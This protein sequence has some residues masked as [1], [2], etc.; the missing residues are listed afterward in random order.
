M[1]CTVIRCKGRKIR[2]CLGASSFFLM[3][4]DD[5]CT[6]IRPK[7]L[8]RDKFLFSR[9]FWLFRSFCT[10]AM[11]FF[12]REILFSNFKYPFQELYYK[13]YTS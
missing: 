9:A 3:E 10:D 8:F 6:Q 2:R 11:H 12:F 1:P 5:Y 7:K 4:A 13:K